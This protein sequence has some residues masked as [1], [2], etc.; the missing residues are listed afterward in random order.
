MP[1]LSSVGE[2][3]FEGWYRQFLAH[4]SRNKYDERVS[5]K[6]HPD[7][8]PEGER[9]SRSEMSMAQKKAL[10]KHTKILN[11]LYSAFHNNNTIRR[12][13]DQSLNAERANSNSYIGN[14]LEV[15]ID[16]WK[17]TTLFLNYTV[18]RDD[19]E[20]LRRDLLRYKTCP[21]VCSFTS[22]VR[23]I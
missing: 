19:V 10:K 5:E 15:P 6:P 4:A 2:V 20:F 7:L 21:I 14:A 8:P 13:I 3:D 22:F 12:W 18:H 9:T 16:G 23:I 11:D 17:C 1:K